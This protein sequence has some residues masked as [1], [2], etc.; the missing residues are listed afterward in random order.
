MARHVA[1]RPWVSVLVPHPAD[2][3]AALEHHDVIDARSAQRGG[4]AD[5]AEPATDDRDRGRRSRDV[6]HRS[7]LV[8]LC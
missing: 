7:L 2:A 8:C 1:R 4:R 6:R 3:L 5:A